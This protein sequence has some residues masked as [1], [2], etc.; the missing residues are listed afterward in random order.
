GGEPND[1]V[2]YPFIG[3]TNQRRGDCTTLCACA[4]GTDVGQPCEPSISYNDSRCLG[5]IVTTNDATNIEETTATLNGFLDSDGGEA[6][7]VRFDW[8]DTSSYTNNTSW[9][10]GK[11]TGASFSA[12]LGSLTKGKTYHFQAEA[13]NTLFPESAYGLDKTFITKPDGPPSLTA[14]TISSSQIDLSWTKGAGAYYTMVRRKTGSYPSSPSDGSQAYYDTGSSFN[15]TGLAPST[16]YY[17]RAWS[18]GFEEGLYSQY[19]DTYAQDSATTQ[20][21]PCI[22]NWTGFIDQYCG[23]GA[24]GD[25]TCIAT[26]MCQKNTDLNDC[27]PAQYQCFADPGC[28]PP[29]NLCPLNK[30]GDVTITE[31]CYIEGEMWLKSGTLT[32]TGATVQFLAN[33]SYSFE[34]TYQIN[35]GA[36]T[37][38]LKFA[39]ET[40]IKKA[41]PWTGDPLQRPITIDNTQNSSNLT[42]Y[43]VLVTVDTAFFI[44]FGKM[45]SDCGDMRFADSDGTTPLNYWLE[46][47]CNTSETKIWVKIPQ[48][49]GSST[50][51]IYMIYGNLA[52]TTESNSLLTGITQLREH[53]TNTRYTVYGQYHPIIILQ[54]SGS[55]NIQIYD[56]STGGC[57]SDTVIGDGYAFFTVPKDWINGNY[58][59]WK[60]RGLGDD[61]VG[62]DYC[63][64]PAS[65]WHVKIFDGSYLRSNNNDF[66]DNSSEPTTKGAGRLHG[67]YRTDWKLWGISPIVIRDQ[68][69]NVDSAIYDEVT[70]LFEV[71]DS[72]VTGDP[73]AG[74]WDWLEVN[75]GPDRS[76]TRLG[77]IE[78]EDGIIMEQTGT[79][80]D[81]GLYRKKIG[82]DPSTS[83]GS[84]EEAL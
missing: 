27:E 14:T 84:E 42:N 63:N 19:S 62:P 30:T 20:A 13:K 67:W 29:S 24:C 57:P 71:H 41:E 18:R 2:D 28:E 46:S 45:R 50:K 48:I 72:R 55:S 52:L 26:E 80:G 59:S 74:W 76:D 39:T 37:Y 70:I 47:G 8:G 7:Q 75:T 38:I 16:A 77:R 12:N 49:L 6:C 43:P 64:A 66:K 3:S 68:L 35:V 56:A 1:W 53:W 82:T 73:Y 69:V 33:S 61:G 5:I 10:A 4:I 15:D 79:Y 54:Q 22:P 40:E 17:Y 44:A 78:F 31:S 60:W 58:L 34:E 23:P 25:K 36:G 9:Q 11:T 65:I 81:Y 51:T 21:G 83:V 32:I